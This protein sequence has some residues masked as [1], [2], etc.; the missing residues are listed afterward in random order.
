MYEYNQNLIQQGKMGK[1]AHG[2]R[3]VLKLPNKDYFVNTKK[4]FADTKK[5]ETFLGKEIVPKK[6]FK[7]IR[8]L[9]KKVQFW[10]LFQSIVGWGLVVVT[11]GIYWISWKKLY[12]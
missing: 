9:H 6:I 5:L 3:S 4:I 1:L 2:T 11:F 7:K 8:F 10:N 12:K